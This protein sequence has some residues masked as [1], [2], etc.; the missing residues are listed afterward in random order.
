MKRL[1]LLLTLAAIATAASA[2]L[3]RLPGADSSSDMTPAH[4]DVDDELQRAFQAPPKDSNPHTDIA[5][6]LSL[7]DALTLERRASLWWD[8]ARDVAAVVSRHERRRSWST[9]GRN[10]SHDRRHVCSSVPP[11]SL[12]LLFRIQ[13]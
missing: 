13:H 2:T 3:V 8:Y 7:A 12:L 10:R 4:A 6:G 1:T 5:T 9:G 11:P